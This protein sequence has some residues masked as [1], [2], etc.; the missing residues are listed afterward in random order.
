MVLF[1]PEAVAVTRYLY[2]GNRIPTPWAPVK[3]SVA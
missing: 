1:D 2:R 3:M